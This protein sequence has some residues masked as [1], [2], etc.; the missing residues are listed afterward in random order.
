MFS[1]EG[2]SDRRKEKSGEKPI[3]PEIETRD[4][5]GDEEA[6]PHRLQKSNL[7]TYARREKGKSCVIPPCQLQS[8]ASVP[9]SPA[10]SSGNDSSSIEPPLINLLIFLLLF[11]KNW[12][13]AIM[14]P[15]WKGAMVEE[16]MALQKEWHLRARDDVDEILN[17]KSRLAKEFEIKDLGSLRYFLGMKA[18]RSDRGIFIS[19]R[20]YILDLLEETSILGCKPVNS[21]IEA[22]HHLSGDMGEHTNKESGRCQSVYM[23]DPRT[24]HMDAIYCILRYLKSAPGKRILFSNH[25]HLQLEVF[26]DVDWVGSVDDRCSTF[27]YCTFLGGNLV[28]WSSKKQ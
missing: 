12:Q 18:A 17:L 15:K 22:N 21:P 25:G 24:S 10:D 3:S 9:D 14:I 26:T 5:S 28:T 2:T 4:I 16:M 1:G 19:Q 8:P 11:G 27:G 6:S 23:H 20:K 7:K 13:D